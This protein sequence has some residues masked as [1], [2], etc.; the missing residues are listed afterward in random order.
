MRAQ[1]ENRNTNHNKGFGF[2]FCRR[3]NENCNN[4]HLGAIPRAFL[5]SL[6]RKLFRKALGLVLSAKRCKREKLQGEESLLT[7]HELHL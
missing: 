6:I 4:K 7:T 2:S 5:K 1:L 3:Q